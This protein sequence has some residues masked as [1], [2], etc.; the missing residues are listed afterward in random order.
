MKNSISCAFSEP[1][2]SLKGVKGEAC[3]VTHCQAPKSA[4]H[5]NRITQAWY[6][7]D[8]ATRIERA[9]KSDGMSFYSDLGEACDE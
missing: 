2:T 4:H 5:Y 6:C 7:L 3:N 1:A 9:A 8:C